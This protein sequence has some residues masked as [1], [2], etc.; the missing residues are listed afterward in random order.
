M[1][2]A[3]PRVLVLD[4]MWNKSL[5]AVRSLGGRGW[6]VTAGERT[7]L[8]PALFSRYCNKK[9]VYPSPIE[10]TAE[11]LDYLE[12]ELS[13]GSYDVILPMEWTTQLLLTLPENRSRLERHVKIPFADSALAEMV[14][15]KALLMK[16]AARLGVEIP[17]TIITSETDN[18]RDIAKSIQYPAIIKPRISSGSRG[19]EYV[20]D[21]CSFERLYRKVHTSYPFPVIQEY[22]PPG[23]GAYGVGLLLN[24]D[25]EVRASFVYKR[26]REYPVSGGPSTVRESVSRVDI[27]EIAERLLKSLNWKGIAHVEFRIDPRDGKPK[28]IEVNPRFWGSLSLAIEAGMDFPYLLCKM[29]RDG[30]IQKTDKYKLGIVNRCLIP[31][32]LLHFIRNSDRLQ[33]NPSFFNL[34]IKDDIICSRDPMPLFGRLLSV[35]TLIS[36]REMR[37]LIRK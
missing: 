36:D 5:A 32:D 8:A 26:V 31:G 28:L 7:R 19:M 14:N 24:F 3:Q 10:K 15:D 16:Y 18:I 11:F 12:K 4:G 22:I 34:R 20:H 35:F 2:S 6:S 33:M 23:G 17:V 25:S 21:N 37:K 30:D 27:R 9:I 29:A 13:V 1:K